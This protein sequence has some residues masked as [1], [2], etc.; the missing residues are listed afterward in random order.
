V[1]WNLLSNAV[2]FTPKGGCIDVVCRS[3]ASHVELEVR[4]TGTGIPPAFV[5]HLFERFSQADETQQRRSAGLG[6]GL[7]IVRHIVEAHGG[8]VRAE[9]AGEDRGATFIVRLPATTTPEG[10]GASTAA[11]AAAEAG[12]LAGLRVLVVDDDADAREVM[13]WTL[14]QWGAVVRQAS[15]AEEASGMMKGADFDLLL[16]DIGMPAEDGHS[17]LR[18]TRAEGYAT[19]AIALSAYGRPDDNVHALQLEMAM[20]GYMD[21]APPYPW[22]AARAVPLVAVLRR[23]VAALAAWRPPG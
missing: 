14:A 8:T 11:P 21:E 20:R 9:S 17:F 4:D 6:L 1:L 22:D 12:G 16:V 7:A 3:A 23:L 19:P 15:S 18:R 5:P 10:A 13:E 2:K